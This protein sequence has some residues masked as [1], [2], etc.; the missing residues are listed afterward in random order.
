MVK[1][2]VWIVFM[3]HVVF[4]DVNYA[5]T[6]LSTI[7]K[8]DEDVI[9]FSKKLQKYRNS[10]EKSME[11]MRHSIGVTTG[12]PYLFTFEITQTDIKNNVM[13]AYITLSLGRYRATKDER[14]FFQNLYSDNREVSLDIDDESII[15]LQLM[16]TIEDMLKRFK[17]KYIDDN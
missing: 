2:F 9:I 3:G 10:I 12:E 6:V 7:K 11:N 14:A 8:Y 13:K 5:P 16:H 17:M 15:K 1:I 4:A